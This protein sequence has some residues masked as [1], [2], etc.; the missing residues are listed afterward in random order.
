MVCRR[1]ILL[2]AFGLVFSGCEGGQSG[3]SYEQKLMQSRVQRDMRMREDNSVLPVDRRPAFRGLDFY[4][5]DRDYR[6]EVPLDRFSEPDTVMIAEST[7]GVRSQVRLGRVTL[8]LPSG[9]EQLVVFR[10]E[11]DD[12]RGRMWVPFGD[13]TNGHTTYDAGRYLDLETTEGDS[14]VVDFNQAYN[15]TCAYNKKY[16]CPLPPDE[17]RLETG[18]PAGEKKPNF[19]GSKGT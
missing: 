7:G 11:S 9:K 18:I 6:F 1:F 19:R 10:G 16:S 15:P 4:E 12:R 5:V 14:V 3:Q 2:V 17:N 13:S 8:P